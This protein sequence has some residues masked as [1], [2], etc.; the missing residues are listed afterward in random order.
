MIPRIFDGQ[1]A[2]VVAGGPSLAGFDF[3]RLAGR[4]VIAINRAHEFIPTAPVLWW[5]DARYW[6]RARASILA[7]DARW[8]A[9]GNLEY[10]LRELD[11]SVTQ[12]LFTGAEGFDPDPDCLRHGWNGAYAATHLAA[13]LGPRRI[14]LLGVDLR[15]GGSAKSRNFHSGYPEN[16]GGAPPPDETL[17][18]WEAAF[19]TLA[20]ILAAMGIEVIN[21]S[22]T[23]ALTIWPRCPIE[24]AL[25]Q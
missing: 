8:K 2:V 11:P 1:D 25:S 12:Y 6:R 4:N 21:G 9:T 10:Q 23:S 14:I 20:P 22:P 7:H 3:S 13:H 16:Y 19:S 24:D 15:H 17:E 5:T 18:R